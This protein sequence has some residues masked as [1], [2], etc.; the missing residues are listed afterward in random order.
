EA[1]QPEHQHPRE[2]VVPDRDVG[3]GHARGDRPGVLALVGNGAF[4]AHRALLAGGGASPVWSGTPSAMRSEPST[5]TL[6]P[7]FKPD[8][9]S[10]RPVPVRSPISRALARALPSSTT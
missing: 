1:D 2:D 9:I 10:T 7:A 3:Q 8:L 6:S 5:T 4:G